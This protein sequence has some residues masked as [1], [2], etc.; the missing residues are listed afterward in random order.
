MSNLNKFYKNSIKY[1][2]VNKFIFKKSQNI[3][4]L[5]KITL[6]FG[7]IK[8][9]FKQLASSLLAL[10]LISNQ[11][12][13]ITKTKFPNLV[14]KIKKGNPTGCKITLQKLKLFLF[15]E[16]MIYDIIPRLKDFSGF[17]IK[18]YS[19]IK[20]FSCELKETSLFPELENHYYLFNTISKL[21][22]TITSNSLVMYEFL[23]LL[24]SFKFI[25]HINKNF[26]NSE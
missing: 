6:N 2:L 4:K 1:E 25:L 17:R 14:F 26:K 11:K 21:N 8:A 16:K 10:E 22:I 18:D 5:N 19:F 9:D 7:C 3:T 23:Y 24:N 20:S 13:K 12:G 15:I